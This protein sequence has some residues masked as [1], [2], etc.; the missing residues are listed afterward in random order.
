MDSCIRWFGRR[1]ASAGPQRR[2]AR[3]PPPL[4]TGRL[5]RLIR[6]RV[7]TP[8]EID[9]FRGLLGTR[10]KG[11]SYNPLVHGHGTG[12]QPPSEEEWSAAAARAL[13][14]DSLT[15]E[16]EDQVL[17]AGIDL[18]ATPWFPPIAN[19]GRA[20]SCVSFSL[21]CLH[22]FLPGGARARLEHRLRGVDRVLGDDGGSFFDDNVLV[23]SR[24]GAAT[25]AT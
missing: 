18:P 10:R 15:L 25:W 17:P 21:V 12:L 3:G 24:R 14:V 6:R 11:W 2:R 20:G 23:V 9:R 5:S 13:T 16:A 7:P 1:A 19:Q 8:A 4:G 22:P